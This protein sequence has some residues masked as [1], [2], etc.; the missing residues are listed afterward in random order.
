M[1]NE[2][3]SEDAKWNKIYQVDLCNLAKLH[4]VYMTAKVFSE[5]IDLL[6]S[7]EKTKEAFRLL[8]KYYI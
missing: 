4:A 8:C 6:K 5:G 1:K 3:Y 2:S 7:S